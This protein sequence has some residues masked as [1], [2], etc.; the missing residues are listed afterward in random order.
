MNNVTTKFKP[1]DF[2]RHE[3]LDYHGVVNVDFGM[4]TEGREQF[5]IEWFGK[6][7]LKSAW[8]TIN[9]LTNDKVNTEVIGNLANFLAVNLCHPFG[10]NASYAKEIYPFG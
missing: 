7:N 8:W 4:I 1:L 2:V 9:D 10:S 3:Y 5:S 6:A